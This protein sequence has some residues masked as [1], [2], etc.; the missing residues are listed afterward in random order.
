[1]F[2]GEFIR[3]EFFHKTKKLC[4]LAYLKTSVL[5]INFIK[6][7]VVKLFIRLSLIPYYL[8]YFN[9]FTRGKKAFIKLHVDSSSEIKLCQHILN[10]LI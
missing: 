6:M 7:F 2:S 8:T 5:N 10:I 3:R 4:F 9:C 1:M